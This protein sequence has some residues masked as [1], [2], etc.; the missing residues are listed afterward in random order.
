MST[1]IGFISKHQIMESF[2]GQLDPTKFYSKANFS[3]IATKGTEFSISRS[4]LELAIREAISMNY[5]VHI[6]Y[7]TYRKGALSDDDWTNYLTRKATTNRRFDLAEDYATDRICQMIVS[8]LAEH[9][10]Q[11]V[12]LG[13]IQDQCRHENR[14]KVR[15]RLRIL[16]M[17]NIVVRTG[18]TA[19]V[20]YSLCSMERTGEMLASKTMN[21][22]ILSRKIDLA[23]KAW[24]AVNKRLD[25]G[26]PIETVFRSISST[27]GAMM[28]EF[29]DALPL[30]SFSEPEMT[31]EDLSYFLIPQEV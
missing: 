19:N 31:E 21:N 16:R 10:P 6:T 18:S 15:D 30:A 2:I 8:L 24:V 23:L 13:V 12:P 3:E 25:K 9:A 17:K 1:S 11:T 7:G 4:T 26:E 14:C 27:V 28:A 29:D 22:D 5:L 20:A